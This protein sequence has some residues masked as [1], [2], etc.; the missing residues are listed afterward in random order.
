MGIIVEPDDKSL[1]VAGEAEEI[2]KLF[3]RI[4]RYVTRISNDKKVLEFAD[5]RRDDRAG[6]DG[7]REL[8]ES[9]KG[10]RGL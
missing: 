3:T 4:E 9:Q 1:Y 5:F 7:A 8:T 2:G 6:L 10:R